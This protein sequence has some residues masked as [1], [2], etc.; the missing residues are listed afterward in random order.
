MDTITKIIGYIILG[1]RI[2]I[3]IAWC[4]RIREKAKSDQATEKSMELQGFLM[5]ISV[6]LVPLLH[7]SPFHLLW[8]LPTS[9]VL[10]LLSMTTPLKILWIFSSIYFA[11]WYIGIASEG[12]K[13]YVAGEYEQAIKLYEEEIIKKASA[14]TYFNLGLAYG[15]TG[16]KIGRA[17]V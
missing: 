14:E 8:M 6:I 16:Q 13:N 11:L 7:L 12:R 5:T 2:L 4:L 1:L 15:K 3:T 17:H 9:F 10:G